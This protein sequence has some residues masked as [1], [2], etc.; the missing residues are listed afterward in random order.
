[1]SYS[2]EDLKQHALLHS[3]E[4]ISETYTRMKDNYEWVCI[5]GHHFTKTWSSVKLKN[6]WCH[7]CSRE[8]Q[9]K[10]S[11]KYTIQDLQEVAASKKGKCLSTIYTNSNHDYEWECIKGHVW[12]ASFET[13]KNHWCGRCSNSIKKKIEEVHDLAKKK[14]GILL[15]TEYLNAH[16]KLKWT[17]HQGHTFLKSYDAVNQGSWC[18]H[19]YEAVRGDLRRKNSIE[20]AQNLAAQFHGK[21]L[22]T[23]YKNSDTKLEWECEDGHR[24][25]KS[26][27][28]V[29][30]GVWCKPCANKETGM[31]FRKY[32]IKDM[33][34]IA[35]QNGGECLS[36]TYTSNAKQLIWK[37][38]NGHVFKKSFSHIERGQWC[39][40]CST[41]LNERKCKY[42]LELLFDS[43][44]K[45]RRDLFDNG[46][47]LDGYNAELK[48]AFEYQGEQ[49]YSF[50]SHFHR[51]ENEYFEQVKRDK[52]KRLQCKKFG[53]SLIEIPYWIIKDDEKINFIIDALHIFS[54]LPRNSFD[55]VKTNMIYFYQ[56]NTSLK[57]LEEIATSKG[58][59][60]LS[61]MYI[62]TTH[63]LHFICSEG[64]EFYKKPVE[65]KSGQWC[66]K[67]GYK[68][69]SQK[70]ITHTIEEM[71]KI[72]DRLGGECLSDAYVRSSDKL[73]WKCANNHIFEKNQEQI[74]AG[75]W[76]PKCKK[77]EKKKNNRLK[78]LNICKI[79]ADT[80]EGTLL[81]NEYIT[82]TLKMEWLCKNGHHLSYSRTDVQI[83][84]WC[85]QCE[86]P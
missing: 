75:Q 61:N 28:S 49:H 33:K 31:R 5:D 38:A 64:H 22:S 72:A 37:C 32:S 40:A 8:E 69:M 27:S 11:R 3:G 71:Q 45:K 7:T 26:Y 81:S 43:K 41:G 36:T 84:K 62:S 1:M 34:I 70:M 76:C 66:K 85:R 86:K 15:S 16:E 56:T 65:V 29:N 20:D 51:T 30:A 47:E 44:F 24:F 57:E 59:N 63:K 53:I 67:C 54:I 42:I 19:C 77:E 9:T 35:L 55:Y 82:S 68:S 4:C 12:K 13:I 6:R 80:R 73:I 2:I 18:P 52:E 21:C 50:H 17:C 83:G 58:G 10:R 39:S 60:L 14:K 78:G 74:A 79:L 48:L 25:T 46:L 23:V